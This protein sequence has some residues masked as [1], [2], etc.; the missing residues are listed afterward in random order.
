MQLQVCNFPVALFFI[1]YFSPSPDLF[2]STL[3]L[4]FHFPCG[5]VVWDRQDVYI[6]T[7]ELFKLFHSF[8]LWLYQPTELFCFFNS[9]WGEGVALWTEMIISFLFLKQGHLHLGE[10]NKGTG[11]YFFQPS[12]TENESITF[13]LNSLWNFKFYCGFL[14]LRRNAFFKRPL[15]SANTTEVNPKVF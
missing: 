8:I 15:P 13:I 1:S 12:E 5:R 14:P 11:I 6:Y 7:E 3:F 2:P 10:G 9:S 4:Y